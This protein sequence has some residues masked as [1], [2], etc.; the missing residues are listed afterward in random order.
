MATLTG[1]AYRRS[2]IGRLQLEY[3]QLSLLGH[4]QE[5]QDRLAVVANGQAAL[6]VVADGMGGHQGGA[7]AAETAVESLRMGFLSVMEPILDPIGYLHQAMA[8]AH[9]AVVAVGQM[10]QFEVRPRAT[11]AVC[12]IQ[13][14]ASYWVHV[15]DSRLYQF[16]DGTLVTR[17]RDHSHV[18]RLLRDGS[19][20][21]AEAP[22]HPMRHYV[23]QCLGG[24]PVLPEMTV[25]GRKAL[26]RHD[27]LLVCSD[28]FWS[29][30][31]DDD[32]ARSLNRHADLTATLKTLGDF[33][34]RA[35]A[36]QSDNVTA[37]AV[38]WIA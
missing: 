29:N 17:T 12:L 32:L 23:E 18:E 22:T 31:Q 37:V 11:C 16:R 4:R 25:T 33:S 27:L 14:G 3:A 1:P 30:F 19:I 9:S 7:L 20:T 34:V 15:G 26:Q 35:S 28:G 10:M 6:V 5:N 8:N 13:Q 24:D 2:G 21:L 36:P 38:R